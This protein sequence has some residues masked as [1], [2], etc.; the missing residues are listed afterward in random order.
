MT[1]S[2]KNDFAK[3]CYGKR[4]FMLM[5][6]WTTIWQTEKKNLLHLKDIMPSGDSVSTET[7]NRENW[8]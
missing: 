5:L 7:L 2:F 4:I 1:L 6:C 8:I 3:M